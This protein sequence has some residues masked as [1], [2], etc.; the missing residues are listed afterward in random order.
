M[1]TSSTGIVENLFAFFTSKEFLIAIIGGAIGTYFAPWT[2]WK[3]EKEKIKLESRKEKIR[4]WREEVDKSENFHSFQQT[5]TFHHFKEKFTE[6]DLHSFNF[7]QNT[8][9]ANKSYIAPNPDK[10]ILGRFHEEISKVEKEWG[11]I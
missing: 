4:Q 1:S 8:V 11:L 5:A 7:K 9:F 10:Q 2:K 3:F 6:K